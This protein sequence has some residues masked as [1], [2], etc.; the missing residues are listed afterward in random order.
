MGTTWRQAVPASLHPKLFASFMEKHDFYLVWVFLTVTIGIKV[1]SS[2]VFYP[3]REVL[4]VRVLEN[5][6]GHIYLPGRT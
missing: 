6:N 2:S 1:F 5:G 4:P 3:G